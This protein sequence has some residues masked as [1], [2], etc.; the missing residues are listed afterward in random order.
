MGRDEKYLPLYDLVDGV[1]LKDRGRAAITGKTEDLGKFKVPNLRNIVLTAPY[2]H[3]GMFRTLKEVIDFY[4]DPDKKIPH[5]I[6]RDSTL[7]KPL[8]LTNR[9]KTDLENFLR[10]LTDRRFFKNNAQI[11]PQIYRKKVGFARG[12]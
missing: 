6:N 5:S 8:G 9:E 12:E 7:S 4:N 3:N 10:S 1:S 2:M 11:S